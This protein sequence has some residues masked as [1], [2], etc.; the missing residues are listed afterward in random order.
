MPKGMTLPWQARPS[1]FLRPCQC[2]SI[3]FTMRFA[4]END[5]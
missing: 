2:L 1:T 3:V 5:A 4:K